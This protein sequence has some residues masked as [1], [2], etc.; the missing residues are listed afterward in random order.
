MQSQPHKEYP[1][2]QGNDSTHKMYVSLIYF[3]FFNISYSLRG[4]ASYQYEDGIKALFM[5]GNGAYADTPAVS[6]QFPAFTITCWVKVLEP[7][8]TPGYIYADWS[9]PHQFSIWVHGNW[10]VIFFQFRN[11]NGN[12]VLAMYT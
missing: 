1:R 12:D 5:N 4:G 6:L 7:A 10:T 11:K 8:K 9:T 2:V 3:Y